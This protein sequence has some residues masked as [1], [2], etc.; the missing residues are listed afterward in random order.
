MRVSGLLRMGSKVIEENLASINRR[1]EAAYDGAKPDQR[2]SRMPRLVAVSKTKPKEMIIE[3]YESG[4]RHFGENYIQELVE[5]SHDAELIEKCPD[6]QWHFIGNC[7]S[8]KAKDLMSC[9][10][11]SV[12]ETVTSA[13]LAT[14]LNNQTNKRTSPVSAFVQVNTS[15]EENKNGLPPGEEVIKTVKHLLENCPNLAFSGLMT[16]GDLGSSQKSS[17]KELNPDFLKLQEQRK[18]VS[19][20]L[21]LD[22]SNIE[23]SMGMSQDFE[24]AVRMG[25]S[26]VR[27]GSSIFGARNYPASKAASEGNET[28]QG[29]IG[30]AS[31]ESVSSKLDKVAL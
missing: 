20:A 5:K 27:V 29:I 4:H 14:K 15:G 2:Y 26:N 28:S 10:S 31:V 18:L 30:G 22:E 24:V 1:I 25:S 16:I 7:Q 19:Q 11:L 12:I 17:D 3:A 6:I 21:G 23:L 9:P 8:N 13:K